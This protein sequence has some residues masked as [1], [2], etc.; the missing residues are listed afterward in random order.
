MYTTPD[1]PL[2]DRS[3]QDLVSAFYSR[4]VALAAALYL[5]RR[6]VPRAARPF[7]YSLYREAPAVWDTQQ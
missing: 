5:R 7:L 2:S 1:D 3:P 4:W 6:I